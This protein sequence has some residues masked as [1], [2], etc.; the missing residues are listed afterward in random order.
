MELDRLELSPQQAQSIAHVGRKLAPGG[1]ADQPVSARE[2]GHEKQGA[3]QD[4]NDVD[5]DLR[6]T[7]APHVHEAVGVLVREGASHERVRHPRD[8]DQQGAPQRRP[9]DAAARS[10]ERGRAHEGGGDD[11]VLERVGDERE[12]GQRFVGADERRVDDRGHRDHHQ[13]AQVRR[14]PPRTH[15]ASARENGRDDRNHDVGQLSEVGQAIDE[16]LG[17]ARPAVGGTREESLFMVGGRRISVEGRNDEGGG[18]A[19]PGEGGDHPVGGAPAA[20]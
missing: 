18:D 9:R 12:A 13:R 14:P 11:D 3:D 16:A 19:H 6:V 20:A 4:R 7:E 5:G 17:G 8:R 15:A 1:L 10:R 2:E